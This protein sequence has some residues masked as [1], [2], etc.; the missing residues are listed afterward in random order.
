[1]MVRVQRNR[2]GGSFA[3]RAGPSAGLYW[4]EPSGA[5]RAAM[6]RSSGQM[7]TVWLLTVSLALLALLVSL[8]VLAGCGSNRQTAK[9]VDPAAARQTLEVVLTDWRNGGRPDVWQQQSPQVV[10]QDLDWSR[11]VRLKSYEILGPGEPRDANLYC[12]VKLVLDEP[13]AETRE[14]TVTYCVGTDPVRTVFRTF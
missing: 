13:T 12:R 1:M 11:G 5:A 8:S 9:P 3:G 4:P 6:R 2:Q 14:Q 10:V 7:A